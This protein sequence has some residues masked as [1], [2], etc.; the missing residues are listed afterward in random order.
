MCN[1]IGWNICNTN[2]SEW[3]NYDNVASKS[4]NTFYHS[5][6]KAS[7][8]IYYNDEN[9]SIYKS[10]DDD[11][12]KW[13]FPTGVFVTNSN[14]STVKNLNCFIIKYKS[15]FFFYFNTI[16]RKLKR[17]KGYILFFFLKIVYNFFSE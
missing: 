12:N 9:T 4:Y 2:C 13:V 10:G 7:D 3:G 15:L 1:F 17:K 8:W 14:V 11:T 5:L 6:Y 16:D